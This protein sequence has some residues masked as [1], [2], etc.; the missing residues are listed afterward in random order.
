MKTK[1]TRN[2]ANDMISALAG[3]AV[4]SDVMVAEV[5]RDVRPEAADAAALLFSKGVRARMLGRLQFARWWYGLA[6][7][8]H[9][10]VEAMC[11]GVGKRLELREGL[12][13]ARV[14]RLYYTGKELRPK[15]VRREVKRRAE[16][17][18][19]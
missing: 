19:A 16:R 14:I 17:S 6:A 2:Q 8:D 13:A 9:A 18:R 12:S 1:K 4:G 5:S 7:D 15:R 3:L 11:V 10:T